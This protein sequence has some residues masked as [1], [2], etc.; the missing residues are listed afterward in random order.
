[1][2]FSAIVYFYITQIFHG[3]TEEITGHHAHRWAT[4]VA[5]AYW[6]SLTDNTDES[7]SLI[8]IN[9]FPQRAANS[10]MRLLRTISE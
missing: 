7:G 6:A 3:R 2:G 9:D 10:R 4:D 8:D 5:V 1:L